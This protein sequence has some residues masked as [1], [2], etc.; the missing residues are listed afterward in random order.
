LM[1]HVYHFD[2]SLFGDGSHY[3]PFLLAFLRV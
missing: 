3:R 2:N 1:E